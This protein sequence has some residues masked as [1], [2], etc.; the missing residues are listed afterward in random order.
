MVE[1]PPGFAEAYDRDFGVP[2]GGVPVR[3]D[4]PARGGPGV[5]APG[6][7]DHP[8]VRLLQR[9][10]FKH[11]PLNKFPYRPGE[12]V[13][14]DG[15]PGE[16]FEGFIRAA[17]VADPLAPM[18]GR[19]YYI[20]RHIEILRRNA[21]FHIVIHKGVPPRALHILCLKVKEHVN[22]MGNANVELFQKVSG[23]MKLVLSNTRLKTVLVKGLGANF[24]KGLKGKS[25][26]HF[27]IFQTTPGGTLGDAKGYRSLG[28]HNL[29]HKKYNI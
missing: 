26:A 27:V 8:L 20:G 17:E 9:S 3:P 18:Q 10:K 19:K 1:A 24:L 23:R 7:I 6:G 28:I 22:I 21:Q 13:F 29:L 15:G 12:Y 11:A 4:V 5:P 16:V 25:S 14:E 2:G